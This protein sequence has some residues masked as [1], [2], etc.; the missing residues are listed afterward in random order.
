MMAA[1]VPLAFDVWDVTETCPYCGSDDLEFDVLNEQYY[2]CDC[3]ARSA[4]MLTDGMED[5]TW[6]I[7]NLDR[8]DFL[9]L[10]EDE[11]VGGD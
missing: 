4:S 7:N 9:S 3:E 1:A 6:H 5:E 8:F 10:F 11:R 2:C